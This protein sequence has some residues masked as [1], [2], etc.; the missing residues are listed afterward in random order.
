VRV[1]WRSNE[2]DFSFIRLVVRTPAMG[3]AGMIFFH[4]FPNDLSAYIASGTLLDS[5]VTTWL[6]A[7][8]PLKFSK[9]HN[10]CNRTDKV[11]LT[12]LANS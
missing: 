10:S 3:R 2:G 4:F 5:D 8:G 11:T 12:H 1:Q 6:P 9:R 7:N